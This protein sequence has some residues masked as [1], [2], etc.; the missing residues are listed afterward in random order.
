MSL[1]LTHAAVF[2]RLSEGHET[3]LS[4]MNWDLESSS[5]LVLGLVWRAIRQSPIGKNTFKTPVVRL[6]QLREKGFGYRN[7]STGF[8][9]T[10]VA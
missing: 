5:L 3:L 10:P 9:T 7:L 8:R 4:Q 2:N 1:E 6:A